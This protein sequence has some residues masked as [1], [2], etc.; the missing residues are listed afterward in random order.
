MIKTII[1]DLDGVLV[2][3]KKIHF[4]AL[5][6]ALL[7]IKKTNV[8]S[9]SDHVKTFD[10]LPT[11]KK[12]EILIKKK[13]I[14]ISDIK[15]IDK[16]KKKFT[17]ILLKKN[18]TFDENIFKLFKN[19]SK[20]YNLVVASN[21]IKSTLKICIDRLKIKKFIKRVK[22]FLGCSICGYK[23]CNEALQF[24]HVDVYNKTM[25]ISRMSGYSFKSL[26]NEMRKCR[27]LCANCHAEHTQIQREEGLFNNEINT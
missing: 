16:N 11:K 4:D 8:I 2:D 25:D 22:L 17:N 27:V 20:K 21:A 14:K 26:K 24:D 6:L 18:I 12:L 13:K 9:F 1:F 15:S 19:L 10:G 5:N 3:T 7:K 23:K